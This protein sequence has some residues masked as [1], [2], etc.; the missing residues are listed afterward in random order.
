MS[1]PPPLSK[2]KCPCHFSFSLQANPLYVLETVCCFSLD[3]LYFCF[4]FSEMKGLSAE[5]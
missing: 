3:P 2:L 1:F 5:F 4:V